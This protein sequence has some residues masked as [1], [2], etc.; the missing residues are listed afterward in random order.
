MFKQLQRIGKSFM[1]PIAILPAAGLLLGIGGAFS[2]PTTIATY[3]ILDNQ[4][5]Q[6][7]FNVMSSAGNVIFG[8]LS[9]L[10]SVGLAIGLAKRDKATA[11]LAA[12]VG[13]LVMNGTI[14]SLLSIFSPEG[15]AIDTGVIG[16]IAIGSVVVWLHNRYY[17]I[18]LP[19]VLGFFGGSRF[20]PI[21]ASFAA[22]AIGSIFFIMWPPFQQALI[23]T[24]QYISKAGPI[25]SLIHI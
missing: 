17:N 12:V 14:A 24:G 13:Y 5:L 21:V 9:M 19:Q 6:V 4:V 8:N 7:I 16:A 18:A 2:N 23:S 20:V 3:P 10:L 15:A 25:L 11:A 22:I 1:L